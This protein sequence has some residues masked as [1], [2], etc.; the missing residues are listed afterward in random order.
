MQAIVQPIFSS[1]V[2]RRILRCR[3]EQRSKEAKW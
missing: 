2:K 3:W 1:F